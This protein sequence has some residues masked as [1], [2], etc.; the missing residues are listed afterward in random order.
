MV[1][2]HDDGRRSDEAAVFVQGVEV[3]RHVGLRRRQEPSRRAARKISV[4]LVPIE[5]A[6]AV[7]VDELTQRD[8][9]GSQVYARFLDTAADRERAQSLPAVAAVTGKPV[10][11]F[12]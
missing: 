4:E 8:A 11:A 3:E 12:L 1:R 5:H 10:R 2:Q 9:R 6:A 7:F